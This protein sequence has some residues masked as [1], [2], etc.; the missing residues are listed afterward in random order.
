MNKMPL[1]AAAVAAV[2][3]SALPALA[4]PVPAPANSQTA[5]TSGLPT[6]T[7]VAQNSDSD[8][9]KSDNAT[10]MAQPQT[11]APSQSD[12]NDK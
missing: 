12:D 1:I 3:F 5:L 6:G 11:P 10:P 9:D 7:V 8:S 2:A 4:S